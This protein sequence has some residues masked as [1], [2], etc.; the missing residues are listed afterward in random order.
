ML[1]PIPYYNVVTLHIHCYN[2]YLQRSRDRPNA[3]ISI[4]LQY[5]NTLF[6]HNPYCHNLGSN[7]FQAFISTLISQYNDHAHNSIT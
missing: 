1:S 5:L 7:P 6:Q 2:H 4:A 3:D